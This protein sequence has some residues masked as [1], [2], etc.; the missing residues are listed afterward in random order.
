MQGTF[1]RFKS[2]TDVRG[3]ASEGVAGE[4][5]NL[6][7][8][9]IC[10]I[11]EAFIIWLCNDIKKQPSEVKIA[12]G[13]DSRISADRI[14]GCVINTLCDRGIEVFDCGLSSTPAMFMTTVDMDCDASVQ[15]T[16]SHHPFNRNGLKFFT[17]RG[18]L[19]GGE[20]SKI[21]AIADTD[22]VLPARCGSV[23]KVDYMKDYAAR[24][25]KMIIDEVAAEDREHPLKGYKIAVD[26]GNGAGGFYAYDVLAPLGADISGSRF[27]EPDGMF[28]NHIPNPENAAA[29]EASRK[30]VKE[31][32]SDLGI[33]FDTDVDRAAVVDDTGMEINRNRL[34]ALASS[35][36]LESAP[37][38]TIVTDSV[39]SDGLSSF[40]NE[41]LG[42]V[43][44]RFK[45]GYRNVIDEA[46][47][48]NSE[49]I[50]C[51]LA[52]ETSGHAALKENFFLDDGA[53]LGTKIIIAMAKLGREGRK[54]S[55]ILKALPE[56]VESV[57]HRINLPIDNYKKLGGEV[58]EGLKLF[59]E[60]Q[61][62]WSVVANSYEGVRISVDKQNGDGWL[63][64]RM[65]VHDPVMALNIESNRVGGADI[66]TE[67]MRQFI[68]GFENLKF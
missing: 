47:R 11:S 23:V 9:V 12:V 44:H 6:T 17:R 7:D 61:D 32:G 40:I 24:L 45:R 57:E 14:K 56:C 38:A 53:Y 50:N 36:V 21:L 54:I 48:L 41:T 2:G 35:I 8:E 33:V 20:L 60:Q 34:I 28:P 59:A 30:A 19:T 37:G 3:I 55:S 66:I 31:S 51:P 49:G 63:L 58:L 43:H 4:A 68:E 25:R 67:K 1:D 16:A 15:I 42:G 62:G 27:L 13:H 52:I 5:I 64:L 10:R 65:S 29:M 22:D 39:T 18:G 46:I 26:A